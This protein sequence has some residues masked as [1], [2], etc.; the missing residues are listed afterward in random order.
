MNNPDTLENGFTLDQWSIN[1]LTGTFSRAGHDT[2]VEPKVMDVLVALA[3]QPGEVVSRQDLLDDVWSNVVVTDDVLTRCIS[4]LRTLLGD[5]GK[6]RAYIRTIPKRGYSLIMP[7]GFLKSEAEL[8]TYKDKS[9]ASAQLQK[10]KPSSTTNFVFAGITVVSMLC[11]LGVWSFIKNKPEEPAT[12]EIAAIAEP[13]ENSIDIRSVAVLPFANLSGDVEHEYFSDGLSED[14]RNTLINSG[15]VLVAARTSSNAFKN[16]AMDVREIAKQLNVD[17][18]LE[19]TVRMVDNEL[20]VTAQLTS[21]LDGYPVWSQSYQRNIQDKLELQTTIAQEIVTRLAPSLTGQ[22][23]LIK[24]ATN[25]VKAHEYYLLG[26]HHWHQRNAESLEQAIIHF[27]RAIELDSDYAPA[28]SGLAD[29]Y[30]FSSMYGERAFD[31]ALSLAQPLAV[32]A[33]ELDPMLAEAHA[34][35]G[36]IFETQGDVELAL[37]SY[38]VTV[39]LKPQYAMGQMWLGNTYSSLLKADKALEH[40]QMASVLD[41][42]HPQVQLNYVNTLMNTGEYEKAEL[43]VDS[44]LEL[45]SNPLLLKSKLMVNL[46]TGRYDKVLLTALSNTSSKLVSSFTNHNVALAFIY[47]G[48]FE[49]AKQILTNMQSD[50]DPMGDYQLSSMLAIAERDANALRELAQHYKDHPDNSKKMQQVIGC[51]SVSTERL[52]LQADFIDQRYQQVIERSKQLLAVLEANESRCPWQGNAIHP[53]V[54]NYLVASAKALNLP[55][56]SYENHVVKA[57]AEFEKLSEN[58]W[59]DPNMRII[60]VTLALLTS[61]FQNAKDLLTEMQLSNVQAYGMLRFEP[62]FDVLN[63]KTDSARILSLSKPKFD[64]MLARSKGIELA[65][66]GM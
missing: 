48:R 12:I 22:A 43:V 54:V 61:Q 53:S 23:D 50:N 36:L 35:M 7:V 13:S 51:E 2:H 32:K 5:T 8:K 14:I 47:L 60:Q 10:H 45:E 46:N 29:S 39:D 27:N 19:G 52:L 38:Q 30:V 34:S 15:D 49:E 64:L 4:E 65:K 57:R 11:A 24:L 55:L 58:G 21:A 17:A 66:L 37:E 25:N 59:D 63:N 16:R 9:V 33:L 26:R 3:R 20:R 42:L 1:P 56:N 31:D 40:H 44:L 28:Y 41:P 62:I 18:L 6:N